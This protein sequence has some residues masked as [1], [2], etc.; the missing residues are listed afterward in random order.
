MYEINGI[1]GFRCTS[2]NLKLA[3]CNAE[4]TAFTQLCSDN[5]L[6]LQERMSRPLENILYQ[7][8]LHTAK[9]HPMPVPVIIQQVGISHL[10][11]ELSN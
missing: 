3:C 6:I 11:T 8:G 5:P 1:K 2:L 9:V 10:K 7:G 4:T